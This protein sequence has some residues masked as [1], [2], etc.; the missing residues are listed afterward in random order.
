VNSTISSADTVPRTITKKFVLPHDYS[1]S[2]LTFSN[3]GEFLYTGGKGCVKKWSTTENTDPSRP[4]SEILCLENSFIRSV[5]FTKSENQMLV[6]GE[7]KDITVIDLQGNSIISRNLQSS[8]ADFHY[9]MAL[10]PDSKYCFAC[11]N[12]GSVGMWELSSLRLVKKFSGHEAAVSSIGLTPDG[13]TLITGSLDKTVRLW[14]WGSG[15]Q[16][17][18]RDFSAGVFSLA[19]CPQKFST[20]AVGLENSNINVFD[21]NDTNIQDQNYQLRMHESSVLSLAYAPSGDWLISGGKDK[22][23]NVWKAPHGPT[24]VRGKEINSVLACDVSTNNLIA[25]GSWD[26]IATIYSYEL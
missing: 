2:A 23:V 5:K 9:A 16:I 12:D 24:L 3:S 26:K 6:C 18:K 15:K 22:W 21:Y 14:D 19:V 13:N 4:V 25:T 17:S 8:N 1:V 20:I 10:T 7:S 11:L